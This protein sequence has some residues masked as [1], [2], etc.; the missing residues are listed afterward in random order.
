MP[1]SWGRNQEGYPSSSFWSTENPA[2]EEFHRRST[3]MPAAPILA[4]VHTFESLQG[5]N[6]LDQPVS[7]CDFQ[8]DRQRVVWANNWMREMYGGLPISEAVIGSGCEPPSIND[9]M[10]H[11][12]QQ[13]H[14]VSTIRRILAPPNENPL[15]LEAGS[16]PLSRA[17]DEVRPLVCCSWLH[18]SV[19]ASRLLPGSSS[20]CYSSHRT[21]RSSRRQ[22]A[23]K[24]RPLRVAS[25]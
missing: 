7:L 21:A 23:L 9:H 6:E 25:L 17:S 14:E 3:A 10:F 15:T 5:F 18:T 8:P 24:T 22:A 16:F 20:S 1:G 2:L 19:C 4:Q 12:V 13:L 11:R